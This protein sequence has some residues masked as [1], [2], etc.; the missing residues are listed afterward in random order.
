VEGNTIPISM[1]G[2]DYFSY[3][4]REPIGVVGQIIPWNFPSYSHLYVQKSVFDQVV[5]GVAA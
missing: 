5:E 2:G 1:P 3:T 4:L